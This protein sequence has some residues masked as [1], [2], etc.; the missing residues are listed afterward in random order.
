MT[1]PS[2]D[3]RTFHDVTPEH[4]GDVGGDTTFTYH[5]EADGVV[6]AHYS[7]GAVR[8]GY[9]VGT[10]TNDR[11]D[12]RYVHVTTDGD[13]AARHCHSVIEVRADGGLRM[14]ESWQWESKPGT[15]TSVVEEVA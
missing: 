10:R 7:G 4:A 8:L 5:E 3:G 1:A 9:L 11:L 12:F 2:L 6:W 13:S 14:H 15:G